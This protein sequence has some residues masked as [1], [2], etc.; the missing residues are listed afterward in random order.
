MVRSTSQAPRL[1]ALEPPPKHMASSAMPASTRCGV[2]ALGRRLTTLWQ[3][4]AVA[5]AEGV[6][7]GVLSAKQGRPCIGQAAAQQCVPLRVGWR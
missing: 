3:A 2:C 7:G 4:A 6:Q 1:S 5:A